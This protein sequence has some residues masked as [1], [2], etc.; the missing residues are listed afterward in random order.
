MDECLNNHTRDLCLG[1]QNTIQVVTNSRELRERASGI[2][3]KHSLHCFTHGL[4]QVS[5]L[6]ENRLHLAGTCDVDC[7]NAPSWGYFAVLLSLTVSFWR[8]G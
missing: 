6:I 8:F 5:K 1:F 2:W 7:D 3:Y 4:R